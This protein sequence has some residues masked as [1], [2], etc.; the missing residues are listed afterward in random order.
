M[1][2]LFETWWNMAKK[3]WNIIK[4]CDTSWKIAKHDTSWALHLGNLG[5]WAD[6]WRSK[7]KPYGLTLSMVWSTA[8]FKGRVSR[9]ASL[10]MSW[11]QRVLWFLPMVKSPRKYWYLDVVL[12]CSSFSGP[13]SCW[14][15]VG[16]PLPRRRVHAWLLPP[17]LQSHKPLPARSH[18][19]SPTTTNEDGKWWKMMANDGKWWKMMEQWGFESQKNVAEKLNNKFKHWPSQRTLIHRFG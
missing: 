9:K 14:V 1:K 3:R 6:G 13:G 18:R 7:L 15:D 10:P 16:C 8:T 5:Q 19:F 4:P 2:L 11:A 17:L 12:D